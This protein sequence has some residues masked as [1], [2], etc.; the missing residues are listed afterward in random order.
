MSATQ[1]LE[2]GIFVRGLGLLSYTANLLAGS[3]GGFLDGAELVEARIAGKLIFRRPAASITLEAEKPVLDVTGRAVTNCAVPCYFV[4]CGVVP[5]SDL[6]DTYKPCFQT[7]VR[8]EQAPRDSSV[9]LS[10][11][12]SS[13]VAVHSIRFPVGDPTDFLRYHQLPL[14][15]TPNQPFP[16]GSY[17]VRARLLEPGGG[18]PASAVTGIEIH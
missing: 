13:G 16:S 7:R 18:E 6:P 4:A 10:V 9:E 15:S 12:D 5:G 2:N 8:V 17:R 1:R 3:S 14:Y 11:L